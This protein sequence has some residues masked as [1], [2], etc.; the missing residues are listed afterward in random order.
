[1]KRTIKQIDRALELLE[2]TGRAAGDARAA[3]ALASEVRLHLNAAGEE[4]FARVVGV[5]A[6]V[7]ELAIRAHRAVR[8]KRGRR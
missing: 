4:V 5:V 6:V 2:L 1:M 7:E 3:A 8:K